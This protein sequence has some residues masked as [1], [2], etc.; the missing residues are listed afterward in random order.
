MNR[1]AEKAVQPKRQHGA[2][3]V[4]SLVILLVLTLLGIS[5]M[6]GSGL[7]E[8]MAGNLH[9][10][11]IAFQR[12]E[13]ALREA[14]S[15]L[16]SPALPEFN[17]SN[18]LYKYN[19]SPPPPSA[20]DLREDPG[21]WSSISTVSASDH[22]EYFIVELPPVPP[23]GSSG[24]KGTPIPETSIYRVVVRAFGGSEHAVTIL[25]TTYKR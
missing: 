9:D 3:L 10:M 25:E 18:G 23:P 2:V 14:E 16:Q 1:L 21:L 22:A 12:A 6:Q 19:D 17:G 15:F 4:V 11:N 20:L 24:R 8:K 5:S 7:Q 13:G